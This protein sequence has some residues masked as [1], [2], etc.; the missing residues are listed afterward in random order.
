MSRADRRARRAARWRRLAPGSVIA[1][2]ELDSRVQDAILDADAGA[3]AMRPGELVRLQIL[4][5]DDCPHLQIPRRTPRACRC[6]PDV[7]PHAR[8]VA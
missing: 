2:G 8:G 3:I 5:D 1:I 4:H 6:R 7:V